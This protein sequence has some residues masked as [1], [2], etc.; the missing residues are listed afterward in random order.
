[1]GDGAGEEEEEEMTGRGGRK[2]WCEKQSGDFGFINF[3]AQRQLV[4]SPTPLTQR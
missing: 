4:P 2:I 3:A 1:M